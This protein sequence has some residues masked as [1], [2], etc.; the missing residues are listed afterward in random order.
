MTYEILSTPVNSPAS[1]LF[2]Q[3]LAEIDPENRLLNSAMNEVGG[4][5]LNRT[6]EI[7]LSN[8]LWDRVLDQTKNVK[9]PSKISDEYDPLLSQ[10]PVTLRSHL[11]NNEVK[12]KSFKDVK[13]ASLLP[14]ENNEKLELIHVMP[15]AKIPQHTHEGNE[16][17]LVLHGSYSDEYG[18]YKQGTVQV[19]SD[20]H[21]HTPVGHAQTGCIGLAYT[22]GKIK[23]SG[24]FGKLLNLIAN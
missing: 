4:Y 5:F 13:V 2:K 11:K 22:H 9:S 18:S 14:K 10:L 12:W 8:N 15:G 24:K 1:L 23:F 19:R 7:P 17:F 21:D 6:E 3:C 16:S 20:D